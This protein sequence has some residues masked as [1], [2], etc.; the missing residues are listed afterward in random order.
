[1]H[2]LR[3]PLLPTSGYMTAVRKTIRE[4]GLR[5]D[6]QSSVCRD[7]IFKRKGV[8]VSAE[9]LV[10]FPP[11]DFLKLE[12]VRRLQY[13][14]RDTAS[15][16]HRDLA[17]CTTIPCYSSHE[18]SIPDEQLRLPLSPFLLDFFV[19]RCDDLTTDDSRPEIPLS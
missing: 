3:G 10:R 2:C 4:I 17:T 7:S 19:P 11:R 16:F 14:V 8:P 13:G 9:G 5:K 12:P 1:M 6:Q 15:G 18:Q